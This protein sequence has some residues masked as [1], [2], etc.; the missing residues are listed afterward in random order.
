M[1]IS[2]HLRMTKSLLWSG[3]KMKTTAQ[4][5]RVLFGWFANCNAST[6]SIWMAIYLYMCPIYFWMLEIL[7]RLFV[8]L[9]R[10]FYIKCFHKVLVQFRFLMLLLLLD[11]HSV[12]LNFCEFTCPNWQSRFS[13]AIFLHCALFVLFCFCWCTQM[14]VEFFKWHLKK[15]R[16]VCHL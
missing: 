6:S 3:H 13:H 8:G 10:S 11:L 7:I 15:T 16:N 4:N 14:K 9:L 2:F 12:A 1:W 5:E